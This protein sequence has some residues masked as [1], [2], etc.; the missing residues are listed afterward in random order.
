MMNL[1]ERLVDRMGGIGGMAVWIGGALVV[2]GVAELATRLDTAINPQ[3]L[4]AFDTL[5]LN[6]EPVSEWINVG[7][8]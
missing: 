8:D 5:Y 4:T 2:T 6:H 1:G 3:H 7:H